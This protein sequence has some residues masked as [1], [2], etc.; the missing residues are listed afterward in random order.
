MDVF[1]ARLECDLNACSPLPLDGRYFHIRCCAHILNLIVQ[2]GLR[3]IDGCIVKVR[4]GVKYITLTEGRKI[5]FKQCV[6]A[7]NSDFKLK[8]KKDVSTR[9]NSTFL[10]LERALLA[11][12][13]I[14]MFAKR[15]SSYEFY[16]SSLEWKHI[17]S[18][19]NFLEPFYLIT[20]LFSG[21]D[22]PTANHYFGNILSIEKLLH[23]A[24][25]DED[26][27][28]QIMASTMQGKFDKYWS[29]YSVILSFAVIFYPHYKLDFVK[30]SYSILYVDDEA[31]RKAQIVLSE[32]IEMYTFY[33]KSST[34]CASSS[35]SL[36]STSRSPLP[37]SS[38]TPF[39]T[40][41]IYKNFHATI[42]PSRVGAS[43]VDAYLSV[44]LRKHIPGEEFD[45]L[46]YWKE[47]S[48]SYPILS[49]MAKDVLAIPISSV[50]SESSFSMGG[51]IL[52]NIRSCLS[53]KHL[54]ALV[55]SKNWL[56]GYDEE[57]YEDCEL[58]TEPSN[59]GL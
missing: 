55:T 46:N 52:T 24:H 39:K 17:Q 7:T 41:D 12:E 34:P 4:E 30:N 26:P 32:F 57:E 13:A 19:S 42:A 6:V 3:V 29:N 44:P 35:S 36:Q 22:Y 11:K 33:V 16:L 54:E 31:N 5:K 27:M 15:D 59:L 14:D 23:D 18:M 40:G 25:I 49:R 37:L 53:D 47:Q 28:I 21:S 43:E 38:S 48:A 9:W 50:A 1:A 2:E 51:R 10:M 56:D 45:I 58:D 20:K 8:L